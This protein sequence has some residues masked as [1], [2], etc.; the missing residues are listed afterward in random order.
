MVV[1]FGLMPS[2]YGWLTFGLTDFPKLQGPLLAHVWLNCAANALVMLSALLL[3]GRLDRKLA[4]VLTLIFIVHGALAFLILTTRGAYSNQIMLTAVPVSAVLGGAVMYLKHRSAPARVALLGPLDAPA[5]QVRIA[6]DR[7]EDP[8]TDLRSYDIL[9]T[10]SV[11]DL[12]PEWARVLSRAMIA[13]K[14]VRHV[15]E[16]VEEEQGLV[17][18]DHFD[19]DHLPSTGLTSYRIRKRIMDLAI[20]IAL[21]PVALPILAIGAGAVLVS[22]GRPVLF[23]QPRTGEGGKVF[24]M[25]K[26]RTMQS[27]AEAHGIATVRADLRITPV[28]GFLRRFRIDELP[29]LLNVLKG[30]MSLIGPRPEWTLLSEKYTRDLPAYVYRH[31]VR[32]GITGWAQVR[33]GYASNLD[34]TRVKVGYDLFYI[35]NLSFSLDIQILLR[36]IWTLLT[37]SGA[38]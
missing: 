36:T 25:Y 5:G 21:L 7:V 26:L 4:A 13:G 15:A 32:P 23:V 2:V 8:G 35:K 6:Y 12:S 14:P 22:M 16:Y 33:G 29:Q 11:I 3:T 34:E 37:G 9:L 17:S 28:G 38:R 10:T 27:L 24:R 30:D 31:L 1:S 18:I 19:L 20:V